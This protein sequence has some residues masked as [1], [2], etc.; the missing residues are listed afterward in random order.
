MLSELVNQAPFNNKSFQRTLS[1]CKPAQHTPKRQTLEA[2]KYLDGVLL[3]RDG[4]LLRGPGEAVNRGKANV[5]GLILDVAAR[6]AGGLVLMTEGV[7][8]REKMEAAAEGEVGGAGK[9][10]G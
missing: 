7:G 4:R 2:T 9:A 8:E 3:R 6:V 5:T 10:H 1:H